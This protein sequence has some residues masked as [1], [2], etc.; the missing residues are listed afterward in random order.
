[1]RAPRGS[2]HALWLTCAVLALR[3]VRAADGLVEELLGPTRTAAHLAWPF[4][5]A[6]TR[7]VSAAEREAD[8]EAAEEQG[9]EIAEELV[10]A[11]LPVPDG[12]LWRGRRRVPARVLRRPSGDRDEIVVE[13]WAL[14]GIEVGMPVTTGAA[15]VGRVVSIDRDARTATVRLVTSKDGA[16][17]ALLERDERATTPAP[18]VRFVVGG[19]ALGPRPEV[20]EAHLLLAAHNPSVPGANPR[21]ELV[22]DELLP[23][24]DPYH[25]LSRG[26]RLGR[27]AES[28][29]EG[30]WRVEPLVDFLHGLYTVVIVTPL[31]GPPVEP[32][33]HP[34]ADGRWAFARVVA[35]GDP[36]PWRS[37]L[38][39]DVATLVPVGAAVVRDGRLLG[40]VQSS[41]RFGAD[42]RLLDDPGLAFPVAG[43]PLGTED[44][45]PRVLGRVVALGTDPRTGR[46]RFH[47]RD[48]VAFE[49]EGVPEG[50]P[51]RVRLVTGSGEVGLPGGLVVGEAEITTGSSGGRG[52]RFELLDAADP[53]ASSN[54]LLVR[55]GEAR[56]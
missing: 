19:V 55:T 56:P 9:E 17:G 53:F 38:V 50:E 11:S 35:A 27:I 29:T 44:D 18:P 22:V 15:Y 25:E 51:V 41:T 24:L 21:G 3:P 26:F 36:S 32:P 1:M 37:S 48:A 40:R 39:L 13:P 5:V 10:L 16:V 34:L 20:G 6:A 54:V 4:V 8:A 7:S 47:L 45:E 12:P 43:M 49:V 14:A 28:S 52:K 42:V 46:P 30:D 33:A 2:F 31:S 23:E